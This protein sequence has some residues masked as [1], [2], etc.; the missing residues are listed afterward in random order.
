MVLAGA[1]SS[2][3]GAGQPG[4]RFVEA[5]PS[6]VGVIDG[7]VDQLDARLAALAR[8]SSRMRLMIGELLDGLARG[9]GH[10]SL[11]FSTLEAYARERVGRSG[12]WAVESRTLARR[13]AALPLLRARLAAG[14]LGWCMAEL[15]ARHATP[16]TETAL[17]ERAM[18]AT[19]REMRE[20][21]AREREESQL[22]AQLDD[23][24]E[25]PTQR[26]TL[27]L[28]QPD[29]WLFAWTR[30]FVERVAGARDADE[31][32]SALVAEAFNALCG[33]VAVNDVEAWSDESRCEQARL[34]ELEARRV[35]AERCCEASFGRRGPGG[36][37]APFGPTELFAP[38]DFDARLVALAKELGQHEVELAR[39]ALAFHQADGARRLGYAS[40]AQYARERLGI[41]FASF[42]AKLALAR[43]WPG[44]VR[45]ALQRREIGHEAA[46]LI[47]RVATRDTADAWVERA[48]ERTV[49][50][51]AEDVRAAEL[52]RDI[53][54]SAEPPTPEM[55]DALH[56]MESRLLAGDRDAVVRDP[57]QMSARLAPKRSAVRLRLR[58]S[59]DT[60]RFFR[61]FEAAL[62]PH[63]PDTVSFIE[64]L[65]VQF[66][67]SWK[68]LCQRDEA[69]A[70]VYARDRYTCSS[71][72]CS[73]HDVT[74]HHV[75]LRS[76]G[77][78]DEDANVTSLCTWCHLE[79]VHGGRIQVTGRVGALSWQLGELRVEGRVKLS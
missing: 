9:G 20:S 42:K 39:C 26:L 51:L 78:G 34:A 62:K 46:L 56:Q 6:R 45:A 1:A 72:V 35:E 23:E 50:H 40:E 27:T 75:E 68:H 22:S 10:H 54:G 55:L 24:P 30:R 18:G 58:V 8:G 67:D 7:E 15:V 73:R 36:G 4:R 13:L 5:E 38:R 63:L 79:G 59:R 65:C 25:Q 52:S 2:T 14:D 76:R 71:P 60:A 43:R 32:V 17:V 74:P 48:R 3:Q 57:G 49:K 21:F 12:R 19:V 44:R 41:S 61:G 29:A 53:G 28:S 16:Q 77:G 69:Y 33:A 70:R 31:L 66:W 47:S 37:E 64:L 11:G